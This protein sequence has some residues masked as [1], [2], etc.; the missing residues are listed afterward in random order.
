MR[1]VLLLSL[2]LAWAG[3]GYAKKSKTL[4]PL[5]GNWKYTNSSAINNFQKISNVS[6]KNEYTTEYLVFNE[7]NEF[8]HDFINDKNQVVKSLKGKW[9]IIN[10]KIRITY[11]DVDFQ[12]L[13]NYFFLDK[14]LVL[15][16]NFNHIVFSKDNVFD[17]NN[18]VLK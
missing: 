9:K 15:G 12:L 16:E 10:D 17:N 11:S 5:I 3:S 1:K 13:L 14:D 4:S 7:N 2:F 18:L 8:K 6:S